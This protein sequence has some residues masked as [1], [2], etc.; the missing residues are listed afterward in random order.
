M[1]TDYDAPRKTDDDLNEDSIE[2][3]KSRRVDK[4]SSSVDVDETEQAEGFELPGADLSGEELSVRVIPR[5]ADEFTCSRCFL[6]HHRS[7]LARRRTA[8]WS[9]GSAPPEP[10][11]RPVAREIGS[12]LVTGPRSRPRCRSAGSTARPASRPMPPRATPAPTCHAV[13]E[14]TLGPGERA[15]VPHR[16]GV[17]LPAGYVGLVHPR[18]G[19]AARHG[20]TIVNA[21]GTIDAGYR[22][23]I[24]V[25]LV[26]LDPAEAFTIHAGDRIAQLVIQ[27]VATASFVETDSL[28]DS[29]RG[30]T[31]HGSTGGFGRTRAAST[32]E[33]VSP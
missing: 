30:D 11:G 12:V 28:P 24:L 10:S 17:A 8:S 15:L 31:G 27:Q 16:S 14:V 32:K 3:L 7:Q 9:A 21:P 25:N 23:E 20:V 33:T 22:G 4:R 2:E 29:A 19:L 6:V 18:S 26:N 13:A 5:Q 1:A